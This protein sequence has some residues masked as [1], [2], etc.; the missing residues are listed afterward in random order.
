MFTK[1]I[2]ANGQYLIRQGSRRSKPRCLSFGTQTANITTTK[3]WTS[4]RKP[5]KS[6]LNTKMETRKI[7]NSTKFIVTEYTSYQNLHISRPHTNA[8]SRRCVG[9]T[10]NAHNARLR[11]SDGQ[12]F[13]CVRDAHQPNGMVSTH[14]ESWNDTMIMSRHD[15]SEHDQARA[16]RED[17]MGSSRDWV[18][19]LN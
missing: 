16:S 17:H 14:A 8:S 13:K 7:S 18:T 12:I 4:T 19:P 2:R 3:S 15:G 1:K 9:N 6:E 5:E 11:P 10:T